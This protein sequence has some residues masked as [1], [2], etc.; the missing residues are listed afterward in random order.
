[1]KTPLAAA[2]ARGVG[3][4]VPQ[5]FGHHG[6]HRPQVMLGCAGVLLAAA[7]LGT[8]ATVIRVAAMIRHVF[9][10]MGSPCGIEGGHIARRHSVKG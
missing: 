9:F 10:S 3:G 4:S 8:E 2:A 7:K 6:T 5:Y 1:M